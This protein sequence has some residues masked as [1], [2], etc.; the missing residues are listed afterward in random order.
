MIF[1]SI[2]ESATTE[3]IKSPIF[4]FF[5]SL[6]IFWEDLILVIEYPRANISKGLRAS[7]SLTIPL[8]VSF[9]IFAIFFERTFKLFSRV[10]I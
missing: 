5:E 6:I 7:S 1:D 4:K 3:E 10:V 8:K 2:S 9:L